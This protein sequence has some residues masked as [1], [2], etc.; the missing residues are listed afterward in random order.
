MLGYVKCDPAELLVR[1]HGLYRALYC[2]LCRSAVRGFGVASSPF[3][4]YDFVFLAAVRHLVLNEPYRIERRRCFLHPLRR[5]PAAADNAVLRDTAFCQLLMIREK[6]RDDLAD[7]DAPFFRRLACRLW[8]PLVLG[9]ARRASKK[10]GAYAA[11]SDRMEKAFCDTRAKEAA[12]ADLDC[13]CGDFAGILSDLASFGT[14]GREKRLL[15]GL[16]DKLGRFLYT[17]DALD[18]LEKDE[19]KKAFN[20]VLSA[21]GG[22]EGLREKLGELDAV[23]G[24]YLREMDLI[25]GL[26]DGDRDLAAIC[27]NVVRRGLAAAEKRVLEKREEKNV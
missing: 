25:L 20:P 23:Q 9:E 5:R 4:S 22:S 18:D 6:M 13:M 7:R 11:L 27:E 14:E 24:F 26:I 19:K 21:C 8:L 16:G 3:H 17:L 15:A 12:G 1:Q 2:G 10:N